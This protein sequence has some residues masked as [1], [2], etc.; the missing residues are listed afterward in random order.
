WI[1][2]LPHQTHTEPVI[3]LSRE[4]FQQN[5]GAV[6]HGDKHVYGA[7]VVEVADGHSTRSEGLRKDGT[8]RDA[9]I[10]K[11]FAVVTEQQQ[12][13]SVHDVAD[14]F[15][16]LVVRMAVGN[17]KVDIPIVVVVEEFYTPATHEPGNA[18]KAHRTCEIGECAVVSVAVKR[19]DLL[20]DVCDEQ[21]LPAI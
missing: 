6:I 14:M 21:V 16:D 15:F 20:I 18:A 19:V 5:R 8:R 1:R 7:I 9:D 17:E 2:L 12:R 10:F 4:I 3:A 11:H 13:L